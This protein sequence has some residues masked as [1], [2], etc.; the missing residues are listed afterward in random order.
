[1]AFNKRAYDLAWQKENKDRVVIDIPKGNRTK[2]RDFAK[3]NGMTVTEIIATSV[4]KCYGFN[5]LEQNKEEED[6]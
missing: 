2:L 1:M 4:Q 6:A 5:M 3:R